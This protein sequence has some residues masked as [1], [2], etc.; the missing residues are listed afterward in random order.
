MANGSRGYFF[1]P[2]F[3]AGA[4]WAF[5]ACGGASPEVTQQDVTSDSSEILNKRFVR[6]SERVPGKYVVVFDDQNARL[7][8]GD[9]LGAERLAVDLAARHGGDVEHV[10]AHALRGFSVA[11]SES[12]AKKLALDPN[13]AYVQESQRYVA[14]VFVEESED[15][16]A[17]SLEERAQATQT[18]VT[19]GLDRIDQADRP[20]DKSYSSQNEGQ[21]VEA[22][23]IDTGI[24]TTHQDFGGRA[25]PGF[26]AINDGKGSNDC[27]GHGSHVAGTV[28]GRTWGVAKA[29]D[30]I[31]VR[32]LD[33]GGSGDD[34][35]V[36]AGVDWVVANAKLPA[37]A[38]MSLGGGASPALDDAVRAAIGKGIVF[39]LAAG[40]ESQDA[41]KVSPARTL[42]AITVA[43]STK[44]DW[45]P[46]FSN[47]G[48][49]V[50]LFAPGKS[51][52]SVNG[53]GDSGTATMSGTSMASPHVAGAAALVLAEHP[54]WSP[55]QVRDALV[56]HGAQGKVG[57]LW[58]IGSGSPNVLLNVQFVGAAAQP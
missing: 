20:L 22:Y 38:N 17:E 48:T 23:V 30:L 45:R 2:I 13:V 36:I 16:I 32:V 51:I 40:N 52:T 29:V 39:A 35:G 3:T 47:Y 12:E 58:G 9:A 31:A 56:D 41:C 14:Q 44:G 8:R 49:C 34:A 18:G 10:Y 6:A 53:K 50:D 42:E 55:A 7:E 33:C 26:S 43:A 37:V 54:D 28:G 57:G 15:D 25:R 46:Y 5:A 11:L 27:H 21:G 24:R 19:W 1:R 4:L